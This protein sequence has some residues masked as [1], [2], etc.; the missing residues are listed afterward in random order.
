[1]VIWWTGFDLDPASNFVDGLWAQHG[2]PVDGL[3]TKLGNLLDG[4]STLPGDHMHGLSTLH[5][6]PVDGLW[7]Q[8]GNL[9]D[10]RSQTDANP[11]SWP[12]CPPPLK[13]TCPQ[14]FLYGNQAQKF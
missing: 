3:W 11:P 8:H 14:Q 9:V 6:D 4:L 12:F 13:L 7:T 5:S 1:M 10:G 2:D